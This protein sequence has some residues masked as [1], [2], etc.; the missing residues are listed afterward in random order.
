VTQN[1]VS[2]TAVTGPAS[3]AP[4]APAGVSEKLSRQSSTALVLLLAATFVVF[5]NETLLSNAIPPIQDDLGITASTGQ[6]LTTAFA[7]TLAVVIPT[8]GWLLQRF[9]TRQLF[10]AALS[11]FT[12]GTLAAALAPGFGVLVAGRVVQAM[13]T[14]VMMPL[15]MT[16]VLTIVPMQMRGRIMGRISIV[17]SLAPAIG[18]TVA[19]LLLEVLPWRGLFWVMVPIAVVMLGIGLKLVPNVTETRRVPID[20]LSVVLSAVGFSGLVYGLSSLGESAGEATFLPPWIPLV[21]GAAALLGF[22][23]RQFVLQRSD[24]ALLDLRAF[25]SR[26][27][28]ISLV[29]LAV[30]MLSLFGVVIL[31]PQYLQNALGFE[32]LVVGL[33]LLPGGLLTGLLGPL[34]GRLYDSVGARALLIPGSIVLSGSFWVMALAFGAETPLWVI[35][36]AHILLSLGLAFMFTPLFSAGLGALPPHLYSH[37][38]ALVSTLQQVAGAAGTA[39]FVALLAVGIISAG[40]DDVA[41]ASAEQISAGVHLAFLAGAIVSLGVIVLAFFV[42]K[43]ENAEVSDADLAPMH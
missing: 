29:L 25:R 32:P 2:E 5:L 7:L 20:G 39:L 17:M 23:L 14:G 6:W 13:G 35:I 40:S 41:S 28:T 31:L 43:P 11:L 33:A 9:T 3:D 1:A 19:G 4:V 22:V 8:T 10:I 36:G 26:T 16:T 18:P 24:A 12:V 21:I 42:R 15:M 38:S 34:V 27:F 37:G 30:A